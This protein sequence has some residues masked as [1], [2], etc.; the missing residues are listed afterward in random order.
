MGLSP[1][2]PSLLRARQLA[3]CVPAAD[4]VQCA[5]SASADNFAFTYKHFPLGS[6]F[7]QVPTKGK[8]TW[9]AQ[10]KFTMALEETGDRPISYLPNQSRGRRVFSC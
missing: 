8:G 3:C 10:P 4:V 6:V 9:M 7:F 2:A 1:L 5:V